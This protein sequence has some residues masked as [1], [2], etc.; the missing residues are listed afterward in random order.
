MGAG[1]EAGILQKYFLFPGAPELMHPDYQLRRAKENIHGFRTVSL[2]SACFRLPV[3]RPGEPHP[4]EPWLDLEFAVI[5]IHC[6]TLVPL[7][8]AGQ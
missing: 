3:L 2:D 4:L 1:V 6:G 5:L 8:E 7:C